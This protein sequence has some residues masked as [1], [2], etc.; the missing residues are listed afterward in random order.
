MSS[1]IAALRSPKA[2]ALIPTQLRLPLNLFTTSVARASP[3]KSSAIMMIFLVVALMVSRIGTSSEAD[4]IFSEVYSIRG[5]SIS[6]IIRSW[7]VAM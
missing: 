1:R 5:S 3:S 2:G 4:E 6:A 7:L